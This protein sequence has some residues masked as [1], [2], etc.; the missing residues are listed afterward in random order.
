M[1][2]SQE[3]EEN[4][5]E[6][7]IKCT[8]TQCVYISLIS[9]LSLAIAFTS[10]T[11]CFIYGTTSYEN[12]LLV[13]GLLPI[14]MM[15]SIAIATISPNLCIYLIPIGIL[16]LLTHF[17]LFLSAYVI[18]FSECIHSSSDLTIVLGS[19]IFVVYILWLCVIIKKM[20][21]HRFV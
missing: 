2:Q 8:F 1:I 9:I 6:K 21:N 7:Y 19:I 15:I 5:E 11:K 20:I 14:F 4:R 16:S 13:I 10:K 17:G 3:Y 12:I 18:F